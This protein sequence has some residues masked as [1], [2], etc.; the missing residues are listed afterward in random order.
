[1]GRKEAPRKDKWSFLSTL[2]M[3]FQ[4]GVPHLVFSEIRTKQVPGS[5]FTDDDA[6]VRGFK[7]VLPDH[8]RVRSGPAPAPSPDLFSFLFPSLSSLRN[9]R[10]CSYSWGCGYGGQW[11]R[12]LAGG[13]EE[14]LGEGCSYLGELLCLNTSLPVLSDLGR[15][16]SP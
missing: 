16:P 8:N 1:M 6:E 5:H 10:D 11:I 15:L 3:A 14:R 12:H 9:F 7:W 13:G 4:A 2:Y